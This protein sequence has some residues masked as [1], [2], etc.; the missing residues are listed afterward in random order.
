MPDAEILTQRHDFVAASRSGH[1]GVASSLIVQLRPRK[2]HE[3]QTPES[4][5]R[6]STSHDNSPSVIPPRY[7]ITASK[8]VGNAVTRNRAKRRLRAIVRGYLNDRARGFTDYVLIARHNTA[9]IDWRHLVKDFHKAMDRAE[10][11]LAPTSR[12]PTSHKGATATKAETRGET[13]G[14]EA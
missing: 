1:K 10:T 12:A 14:E 11:S 5:A 2:P 3:S 13:R 4:K 7:G 6:N 8:K 9:T